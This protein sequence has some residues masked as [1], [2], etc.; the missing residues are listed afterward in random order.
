MAAGVPDITPRLMEEHHEALAPLIRELRKRSPVVAIVAGPPALWHTAAESVSRLARLPVDAFRDIAAGA[1]AAERAKPS[2]RVTAFAV[3]PGRSEAL[4]ALNAA[5]EAVAGQAPVLVFVDGLRGWLK[6]RA[7]APAFFSRRTLSVVLFRMPDSGPPVDSARLAEARLLLQKAATRA[8]KAAG[9]ARLSGQLETDNRHRE[10]ITAARSGLALFPKTGSPVTAE[11]LG[12]RATFHNQ[13]ASSYRRMHALARAW[14]E[15]VALLEWVR[16]VKGWSNNGLLAILDGE[17]TTPFGMHVSGVIHLEQTDLSADPI[18]LLVA[19]AKLA[20]LALLRGDFTGAS[21]IWGRVHGEV[22]GLPGSSARALMGSIDIMR[23][24]FE[25]AE[26]YLAG[27]DS[28]DAHAWTLRSIRTDLLRARGQLDEAGAEQ[29]V[30]RSLPA[31]REVERDGFTSVATLMA[32]GRVSEAVTLAAEAILDAADEGRDHTIY[33]HLDHLME[34]VR[35]AAAAGRLDPVIRNQLEAVLDASEAAAV[36]AGSRDTPWAEVIFPYLRARMVSRIPAGRAAALRWLRHAADHARR[37]WRDALARILPLLAEA[38][39]EEGL[40]DEA[41]KTLTEGLAFARLQKRVRD[42]AQLLALDV[43]R[44]NVRGADAATLAQRVA[45]ME[46]LTASMHAPRV[47]AEILL[48]L[49]EQSAA[50]RGALD[51][52]PLLERA[53]AIFR[54]LPMPQSEARCVELRGDAAQ[55]MGQAGRARDFYTRSA[56]LLRRHGCGMRLP[57]VEAK[58]TELDDMPVA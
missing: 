29:V 23:G 12:F 57:V 31:H 36:S 18:N 49:A 8:E 38:Q 41:G 37:E 58:L 39:L 9:I 54:A 25:E 40:V 10:A 30:L 45:A 1:P 46:E 14:R 11:S 17:L 56:T 6:V 34:H 15:G 20:E 48:E 43:C 13:I 26:A 3:P 7:E 52:L 4:A 16:K 22:D 32:R 44:Q 51:P 5:A 33:R 28:S 50:W 55:R 42:E 27:A 47:H 53:E 19:Q 2:G 21:A 35:H 24:R